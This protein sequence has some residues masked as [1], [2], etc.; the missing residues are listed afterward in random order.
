M[1]IE[2]LIGKEEEVITSKQCQSESRILPHLRFPEKLSNVANNANGQIH[3][4]TS[5][6][7]GVSNY[8]TSEERRYSQVDE[9]VQTPLLSAIELVKL[10]AEKSSQELNM[11]SPQQKYELE[12]ELLRFMIKLRQL[13]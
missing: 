3:S 4:A 13:E 2:N 12:S 5:N 8:D 9:S 6:T 7:Q 1:A 10:L 11:F